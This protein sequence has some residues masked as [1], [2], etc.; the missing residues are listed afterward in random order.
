MRLK[1]LADLL[2]T[3]ADRVQT[4]GEWKLSQ[5]A[6]NFS[7]IFPASNETGV[8]GKCKIGLKFEGLS[9]GNRKTRKLSYKKK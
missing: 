6:S 7:I 9:G 8:L 5:S 4:L 2:L 1:N 3:G